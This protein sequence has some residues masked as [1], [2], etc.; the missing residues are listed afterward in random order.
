MFFRWIKRH[1]NL[2]LLTIFLLTV[3]VS[4]FVF[5][6]NEGRNFSLEKEVRHNKV[7]S[8]FGIV[9][10]TA[11]ALTVFLLYRQTLIMGKQYEPKLFLPLMKHRMVRFD[12]YED[13]VTGNR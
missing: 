3:I 6:W 2:I 4:A 13:D 11:T 7:G 8:F 9:G 5:L 12:I 10:A 1:L